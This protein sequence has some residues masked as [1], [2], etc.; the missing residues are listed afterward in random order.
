MSLFLLVTLQKRRFSTNEIIKKMYRVIRV[1]LLGS[2]FLYDHWL[3]YRHCF[4]IDAK[5]WRVTQGALLRNPADFS[6]TSCSEQNIAR[7]VL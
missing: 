3:A 7:G 1:K 2:S 6:L 4:V 5:I